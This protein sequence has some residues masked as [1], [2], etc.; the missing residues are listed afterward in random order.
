[1]LGFNIANTVNHI[2]LIVMFYKKYNLI[3]LLNDI[4]SVRECR[5]SLGEIIF[6][7]LVECVILAGITYVAQINFRSFLLILETNFIIK[8]G[9]QRSSKPTTLFYQK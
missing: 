1:M 5:L 9:F 8:L 7:V 2:I 6:V 3:H 4:T